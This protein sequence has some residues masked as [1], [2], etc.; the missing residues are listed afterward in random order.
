MAKRHDHGPAFKDCSTERHALLCH[1]KKPDR[2]GTP[3]ET[4]LEA[5]TR[6]VNAVDPESK[7]AGRCSCCGELLRFERAADA[8]PMTAATRSSD[9]RDAEIARLRAA[10]AAAEAREAVLNLQVN[11]LYGCEKCLPGDPCARFR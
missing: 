2:D 4:R 1:G 3:T 6:F 8:L 5:F 10:L 9:Q 7:D 11:H